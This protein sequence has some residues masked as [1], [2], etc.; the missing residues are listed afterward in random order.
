MTHRSPQ[1]RYLPESIYIIYRKIRYLKRR[2][3]LFQ[4]KPSRVNFRPVQDE[5]DFVYS[6]TY[7]SY[8]KLRFLVSTGRLFRTRSKPVSLTRTQATNVAFRKIRYLVKR[9]STWTNL[10]NSWKRNMGRNFGFLGS[11]DYIIILINSTVM[12]LLAYLFVHLLTQ[13]GVVLAATNFKIDTV[14]YYHEIDF[15]IRGRDWSPD[16]VK[17]VYT[18][19][20]FIGL[21]IAFLAFV[22]YSNIIEEPWISR[23]FIMWVFCHAF[24]RFF[25]EF[26][27]GN[28]LGE[29][30]GYVVM[31]M[32]LM[33]TSKMIMTVVAFIVMIFAGLAMTRQFMF[34]G[35]IYFNM[36]NKANRMSFVKAQYLLPC[37]LGTLIIILVDLPKV[38]VLEICV[39]GSMLLVI[40]PVVLRTRFMQDMYYEEDPKKIKL[41]WKA[42]TWVL[43]LYILFRIIFGIGIRF[44]AN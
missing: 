9:K 20:P 15:L 44:W 28:L 22:V 40:L 16:A 14:V 10:L 42:I 3:T 1:N 18:T 37:L 30:F 39:L 19:G 11:S 6:K 27:V 41:S 25:G 5:T 21:I 38:T 2:G 35:N 34:M 4:K 17:V 36:L 7:K 12:F 29:G 33:D 24:V 8:R 31:Y 32:F 13:A 26:L 43:V 23:L